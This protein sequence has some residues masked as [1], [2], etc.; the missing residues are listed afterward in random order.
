MEGKT[1]ASTAV[2]NHT[3]KI[4]P[5]DLNTN[6]TVFGGL[7][8]ATLD[9]VSLVVAERH[10]GS[11][12]ATVSVDALHFLRPAYEGEVLIFKASINRSWNAS[13]EIGIRVCSEN[14]KSGERRHVVSAYFTFVALDKEHRPKRVPPVIPETDLQKRRYE[15]AGLRREARLIAASEKRERRHPHKDQSHSE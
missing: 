4:F 10:S 1:V 11:A 5:S 12:C 3:Y 6:N 7:V 15:E 13:M 2:E 9:R 14:V 8:M